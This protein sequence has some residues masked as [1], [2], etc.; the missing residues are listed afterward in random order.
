MRNLDAT[1]EAI[2]DSG[3]KARLRAMARK[4]HIKALLTAVVLSA[5]TLLL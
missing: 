3:I 5:F 1:D 4:V 2:D